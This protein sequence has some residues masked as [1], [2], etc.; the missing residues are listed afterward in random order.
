MATRVDTTVKSRSNRANLDENYKNG[1]SPYSSINEA[2]NK[3]FGDNSIEE[4]HTG[5]TVLVK[6]SGWTEAKEYWVQPLD[7]TPVTYGFVEK[8]AGTTDYNELD[9]KPTISDGGQGSTQIPLSGNVKVTASTASGKTAGVTV[10]PG[11]TTGEIEMNFTLPKGNDAYEVYLEKYK[12]EHSGSTDGVMSKAEWL[13]SLKGDTG[14]DGSDG[15]DGSDGHNPCLGRYNALPTVADLPETPR[16]GDYIYVD[17][18][19]D[20]TNVV[21]TLYKYDATSQTG[22]DQGTVVDVSNLT[23]NSGESVTGTSIDGTGLAN[24]APNA[25]AKAWDAM[26]LAA[27]LEGV[28]ASETKVTLISDTNFFDGKYVKNNK[29]I[30]TSSTPT[31]GV[32]N[33]IL[34]VDVSN[35]KKI[36]FLGFERATP[37]TAGYGFSAN[38]I[39]PTT[40]DV[41]LDYAVAFNGEADSARVVEIEVAVP[42]GMNYFACTIYKYGT[43]TDAVMTLESFYCYLYSGDNIIDEITKVD[44]KIGYYNVSFSLIAGKAIRGKTNTGVYNAGDEYPLS[45]H[46]ATSF[47]NIE[48]LKLIRFLGLHYA[49]EEDVSTGYWFY[50][51]NRSPL[52]NSGNIWD[53]NLP[54]GSTSEAIEYVVEIPNNAKYF[55]CD[56]K[57]TKTTSSFYIQGISEDSIQDKLD[58][59][60]GKDEIGEIAKNLGYTLLPGYVRGGNLDLR[61]GEVDAN[62]NNYYTDFID[63]SAID[64]LITTEIIYKSSMVINVVAGYAFYDETKATI[65]GMCYGKDN[66]DETIVAPITIQVPQNAKYFRI[67]VRKLN[68]GQFFLYGYKDGDTVMEYVRE[69]LSNSVQKGVDYSPILR[70][71]SYSYGN[72]LSNFNLIHFSDIH[73]DD[74]SLQRIVDFKNKYSDYITD[75]LHTGDNVWYKWEHGMAFWD[76]VNGAEKILNCLGNHDTAGEGGYTSGDKTAAE[77]RA[78][79]ITPYI[80]NWGDVVIGNGD[81]CYYYKDYQDF[82]VR[83]IVL[84]LYHSGYISGSG[85]DSHSLGTEQLT[86]FE[87]ALEGARTASTPLHVIVAGHVT[88]RNWAGHMDTP[89]DD[90]QRANNYV[91]DN[92]LPCLGSDAINAISD[93]IDDGG[94][95]VCYLCG[96]MHSD[97]FRKFNTHNNMLSVVVQNGSVREH[98]PSATSGTGPNNSNARIIGEVSED[99]FNVVSVDTVHSILTIV[100]IGQNYDVFGRHLGSICY[101]YNAHRIISQW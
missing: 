19:S 28:T 73:G 26:Q 18:K 86:W 13:A 69:L 23:F 81:E 85:D 27:K 94:K 84:D 96:H 9:N 78:R 50:D 82:G 12:E 65:G 47:I 90:L 45:N 95:F 46:H 83:L 20:Q 74:V 76:A 71:L 55:R 67:T 30:Q 48:G 6:E 101:D 91:L 88:E 36:R 49:Q 56:T 89:F 10:T 31:G 66:V 98:N 4:K 21:T 51:A 44:K 79:Y 11:Q 58:K 54:Q 53:K 5:L 38:P 22:F 60:I 80:S 70:N 99:A 24:P 14:N 63:V 61:P 16:V 2:K 32:A 75:V 87:S 93:F 57:D 25:L 62:V 3:I 97:S 1:N 33:G 17:D 43:P 68:L 15:Q 7:T 41:Q 52:P 34:I 77:C 37:T 42:E 92:R 35:A 40:T 59:K 64:Y 29:T 72:N 100:R 8:G 39:D